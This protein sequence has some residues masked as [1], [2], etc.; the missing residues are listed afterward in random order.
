MTQQQSQ[1]HHALCSATQ[2]STQAGNQDQTAAKKLQENEI[3]RNLRHKHCSVNIAKAK[4]GL[5]RKRQEWSLRRD[6]ELQP[7]VA[8][9]TS[10][11]TD[12]K[13]KKHKEHMKRDS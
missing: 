1:R 3:Y 11:I 2:T 9:S 7:A 13:N 10:T 5:T 12:K 6:H 8:G 4:Q